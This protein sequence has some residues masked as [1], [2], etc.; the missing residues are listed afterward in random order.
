[1]VYIYTDT[2]VSMNKGNASFHE[3]NRNS[4]IE[5]PVGARRSPWSL[6]V[7]IMPAEGL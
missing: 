2:L 5:I 4:S 3:Q 1:M 6:L 7:V